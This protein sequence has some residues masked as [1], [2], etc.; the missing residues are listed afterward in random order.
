MAYTYTHTYRDVGKCAYATGCLVAALGARLSA[1][2][3]DRLSV[4]QVG[5]SFAG[6]IAAVKVVDVAEVGAEVEHGANSG[7]GAYF[8]LAA[9]TT[10]SELKALVVLVVGRLASFVDCV[11]FRSRGGFGAVGA[12]IVG[13]SPWSS[14]TSI[15]LFGDNVA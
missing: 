11:N 3:F 2:T 10:G 4:G 12:A 9:S 7:G 6:T 14:N 1:G 15:D 13:I 5:E 8:N